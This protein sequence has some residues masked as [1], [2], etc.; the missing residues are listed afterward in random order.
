MGKQGRPGQARRQDLNGRVCG[1]PQEAAARRPLPGLSPRALIGAERVRGPRCPP[2]LAFGGRQGASSL[3]LA[4]RPFVSDLG[5]EACTGFPWGPG[6]RAN[7]ATS[8]QSRTR[9]GSNIKS[10]GRG[11]WGPSKPS[12]QG[13][14]GGNKCPFLCTVTKYARQQVQKGPSHHWRDGHCACAVS[15]SLV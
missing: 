2:R 11:A 4:F 3:C 5:A 14:L 1:E 6:I 15:M 8:G 10:R 7:E 9:W 12:P 13:P